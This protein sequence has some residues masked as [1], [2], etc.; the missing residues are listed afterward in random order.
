M[1]NADLFGISLLFI[2]QKETQSATLP[3]LPTVSP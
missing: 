1:R 3:P 2:E